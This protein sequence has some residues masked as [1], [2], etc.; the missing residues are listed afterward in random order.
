[1]ERKKEVNEENGKADPINELVTILNY[2]GD[3]DSL[4]S[5]RELL[6]I[7]QAMMQLMP[8]Y[9]IIDG[10]SISN[11]IEESILPRFKYKETATKYNLIKGIG[12]S[13]QT[14]K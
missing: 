13:F 9:E 6:H 14:K 5:Y 12:S 10:K 3:V 4:Y 8:L 7:L 1:M 11:L 2:Y